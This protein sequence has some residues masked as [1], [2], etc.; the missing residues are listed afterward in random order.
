MPGPPVQSWQRHGREGPVVGHRQYMGPLLDGATDAAEKAGSLTEILASF[1][2]RRAGFYGPDDAL[3]SAD[4][5]LEYPIV[6]LANL[7]SR[8]NIPREPVRREQDSFLHF[9]VGAETAGATATSPPRATTTS[10]PT[11]RPTSRLSAAAPVR[12]RDPCPRASADPL[13]G[14]K[15]RCQG[16]ARGA[17]P[18][19][20]GRSGAGRRHRRRHSERAGRTRSGG[21]PAVRSGDPPAARP[22]AR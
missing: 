6:A 19:A 17:R 8:R 7:G 9:R 3:V 10:A 14:R 1:E 18:R 12:R 11:K 16:S 15:A 13:C 2:Q 22:A 20:A 21:A 5:A 4:P